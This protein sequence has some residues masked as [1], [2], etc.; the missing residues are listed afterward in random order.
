MKYLST[1]IKNNFFMSFTSSLSQ[2]VIETSPQDASQQY[3][4]IEIKINLESGKLVYLRSVNRKH[5]HKEAT[6]DSNACNKLHFSISYYFSWLFVVGISCISDVKGM[7]LVWKPALDLHPKLHILE[8]AGRQYA[9]IGVREVLA[10]ECHF[11][12]FSGDS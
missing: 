10:L 8:M 4:W 9:G 6:V 11:S 3:G 1:E 7:G 12:I 2:T 5:L